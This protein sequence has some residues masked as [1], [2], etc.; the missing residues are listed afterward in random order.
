MDWCLVWLAQCEAILYLG[1][2][3]GADI[4]LAEA[5]RLGLKIYRSVSEIP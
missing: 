3:K 5:E 2:S 1:P 4:E